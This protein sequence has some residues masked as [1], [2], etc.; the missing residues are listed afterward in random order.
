M[1]KKVKFAHLSTNLNLLVCRVLSPNQKTRQMSRQTDCK[2]GF[3]VVGGATMTT[4]KTTK[5]T[6]TTRSTRTRDEDEG[7]GT[8]TMR[9]DDEVEVEDEDDSMI[10]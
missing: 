10:A 3:P 5:T 8:R 6:N 7:R 1:L 9:D 4:T 2:F